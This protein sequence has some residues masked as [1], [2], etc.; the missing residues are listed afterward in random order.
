MSQETTPL[1]AVAR[2]IEPALWGN[3][4]AYPDGI[5]R[6]ADLSR[7]RSKAL[8]KAKLILTLS[9]SS[10][11]EQIVAMLDYHMTKGGSSDTL[12]ALGW[13]RS[14]IESGAHQEKRG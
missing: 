5:E 3:P 1:E 11:R 4:F 6:D 9:S 13:A 8:E 10:E 2:I 12:A 7:A 14:A